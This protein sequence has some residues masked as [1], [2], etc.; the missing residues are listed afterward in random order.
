MNGCYNF[1]YIIRFYFSLFC[2]FFSFPFIRFRY[3][4]AILLCAV[5]SLNLQCISVVI[6]GDRIYDTYVETVNNFM[7]VYI[8]KEPQAN[9]SLICSYFLHT[10]L[11]TAV[12]FSFFYLL[13]CLIPLWTRITLH[14]TKK[15]NFCPEFAAKIEERK[16]ICI[17]E[18]REVKFIS[19]LNRKFNDPSALTLWVR[20][21]L[22]VRSAL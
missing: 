10:K 22:S 11:I 16:C 8:H 3:M 1:F 7:N 6:F 17:V 4:N 13:F 18:D 5:R 9:L 20:I 12:E 19:T 2:F 21:I 14:C 15:V